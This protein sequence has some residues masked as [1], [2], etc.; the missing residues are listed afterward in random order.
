MGD[1]ERIVIRGQLS[2]HND[3]PFGRPT[4]SRPIGHLGIGH[5]QGIFGG[6]SYYLLVIFFFNIVPL[7]MELP[8]QNLN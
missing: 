5:P 1:A 6:L 2:G 7:I 8:K 3:T 4:P